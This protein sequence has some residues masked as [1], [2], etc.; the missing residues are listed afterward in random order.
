MNRPAPTLR[1]QSDM[2]VRTNKYAADCES[3]FGRVEAE[4]GILT[5]EGGQWVVRHKPGRCGVT[6]P[7]VQPE[8]QRPVTI[9]VPDGRYTIQFEDG[10]YKTLRVAAQA[11]DADFMPGRQIVSYL[12]G[13]NNDADYT[14]FAHFLENGSLVVWKR[15]QDN[16]SLREAVK[17]L[18]GSPQAAA[19]AYAEQSGC[20]ARCGRTLTVPSS[21]HAGFGPECAKKVI[22]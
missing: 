1:R 14:S 2:A 15:H 7:E 19:L 18:I 21:L 4:Q 9:K 16:R 10:T 17:V 12:S 6:E 22:W 5:L 3:C 20:C 8:P 13:S 11:D